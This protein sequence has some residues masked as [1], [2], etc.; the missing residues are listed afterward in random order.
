[1]KE[2]LISDIRAA[3]ERRDEIVFTGLLVR[4]CIELNLDAAMAANVFDTSRP[5]VTR[6]LEGRA[7]PSAAMTVYRIMLEA[8]GVTA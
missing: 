4:T 5:N 8:L 1:M 2:E 7:V 6:W 3:L